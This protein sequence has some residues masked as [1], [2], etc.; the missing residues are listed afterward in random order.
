MMKQR[1]APRL[2]AAFN[3]CYCIA[4]G[5]MLHPCRAIDISRYGSRISMISKQEL[6]SGSKIEL[7]IE[8]PDCDRRIVAMFNC[9]WTRRTPEADDNGGYE[10]GGFFTEV[11][12]E[13]RDLLL[14]CAEI[15]A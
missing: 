15:Q 4:D 11:T 14:R 12:P 5:Q 2:K 9:V 8:I 6:E 3:A 1:I 10:V 13:E 7:H